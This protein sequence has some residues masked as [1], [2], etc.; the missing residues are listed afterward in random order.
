MSRLNPTPTPL[1][2]I[3]PPLVT[4][5]DARQ[6]VDVASLE[7]LLEH[8][9]GAG[10]HGVFVL[11]TT[12][13]AVALDDDVRR[14]LVRRTCKVV[15]GRV[16]VLV[17]ITDTCVAESIRLA[18]YSADAGASAVVVSAPFY[19][20]LEQQEV[21]GYVESIA[22]QQSLPIFLY[23]IPA[24]SKTQ[25]EAATVLRLADLPSV[26]GMKDSSGDPSYLPE[27]RK[28]VA[29][30]DWSFFVGTEA[31]LSDAVM[32]GSHGCVPGGA[33]LD[34]ALF[35]ALYDA[36]VRGDKARVAE[37]Q[38]RVIMLDR[39]YRTS[40][41][42]ASIV[43]GLKC[44]MECLGICDRRMGEPLRSATDEECKAIEHYVQELGLQRVGPPVRQRLRGKPRVSTRRP[45]TLQ[46]PAHDHAPNPIPLRS[47]R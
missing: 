17:G 31:L 1:R 13:E 9:I 46:I 19:L 39:I 38:K 21:I 22:S 16:P 40:P 26:I 45:A 37:L 10:V 30:D 34:P 42:A 2:G 15:A 47:A 25:Y 35:V 20:P 8:V 33:N 43:R 12:G 29:R 14:Q 23:N 41:G 28:H 18:R 24:L 27:L 6:Q 32:N 11:G 36:A 5:L 7:R 44:A 4:P 3:V